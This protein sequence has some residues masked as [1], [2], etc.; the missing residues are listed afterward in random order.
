[1]LH[2]F[3][4]RIVAGDPPPVDGSASTARALR[5]LHPLDNGK[6]IQLP[7]E[8]AATIAE[9]QDLKVMKKGVEDK[10]ALAE[11]QIKAAIGDNTFG[12]VDGVRLSWKA[13]T[14]KSYTVAEST[15]RVLRK[16][17]K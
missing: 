13:Q 10:I 15:Y 6:S 9:W 5:A 14:R 7:A 16:V 11:N 17:G 4:E 2:E 8:F 1:V 3:W 12:E